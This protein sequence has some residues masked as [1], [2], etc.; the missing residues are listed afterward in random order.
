MS[1]ITL[2]IATLVDLDGDD[3]EGVEVFARMEIVDNIVYPYEVY[4]GETRA[5]IDGCLVSSINDPE[6]LLQ[7]IDSI[8]NA[9]QEA[10]NAH[11]KAEKEK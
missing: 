10:Y 2:K 6:Y 9:C 7:D 5:G 11:I 3:I 1:E 4:F 8:S